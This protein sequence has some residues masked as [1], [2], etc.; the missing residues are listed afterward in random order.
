MRISY[1]NLMALNKVPNEE[2][3]GLRDQE[4]STT[5]LQKWVNINDDIAWMNFI[6]FISY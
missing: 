4:F 2:R 6:R 3:F 5:C 1:R